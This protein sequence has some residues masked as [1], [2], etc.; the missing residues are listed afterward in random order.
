[1][2][3]I[4]LLSTPPLFAFTFAHPAMLA[5][6]AAAAAPILIHLWSRRR[7]RETTWAA[8]EYL[9]AALRQKRRKL[10]LEHWLLLAVRTLIVVLV[11]LAVAEPIQDRGGLAAAPGER[12]HR[13][14][15]LDGSFS[16]AYTSGDKSRFE[17][18]K[19]IAARIVRE[20]SQGDGFTL[21]VMSSPPRVVVRKPSLESEDFVRELNLL[22]LTHG[23]ADLAGTLKEV[24]QVL[25]AARREEPRLT[26][27][28]IYF[29][30]DL[31]RVGWGL[32][33]IDAATVADLRARSERL[34]EAASLVVIDVGHPDAE[35]LAVTAIR[36]REPFATLSRNFEI[37]ATVKRF[38]P[39]A[40]ARQ[41]VELWADGRRVTQQV[42][43]IPTTG[44][45]SVKFSYRFES[46]G[47]HMLEVRAPGDLL[48]VDNRRW[49]VVP[50]KAS[51]PVLCVDGRSSAGAPDAATRYLALALS[52]PVGRDSPGLV[53]PEIVAESRLP[54]LTLDRFDCIFLA[55]VAQ[56]TA[57]EARLLES[58]VHSGGNLVFFLGDR[59]QAERYNA[60]LG[61]DRPGRIHLLPARL[62]PII[63]RPE[64]RLN[65]LEY[66]H[67]MIE[68]FRG[69][70][71]SGLLTALVMKHIRLVLPD[72]SFS[73]EPTATGN[74]SKARVVLSLA[75]GDPLIVEEPI[76]RGR[77]VLVATSADTTWTYLPLWPSYVP[78]IQETLDFVI[79]GQ[80]ERR[81]VV[82]GE[83]IGGTLPANAGET[84][85]VVRDPRGRSDSVRSRRESDLNVWSFADTMI[86]G[87]YSVGRIANP[88][89]DGAANAAGRVGDPSYGLS[90]TDLFAVNVD[91]A[92]SD[93]AALTVEQLRNEVWPGI[94]FVHQTSL[95]HFDRPALGR[96]SRFSP[97]AID[98]LSGVL[99]LLLVETFLARRF[100]H[101]D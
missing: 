2:E 37:E 41:P 94:P 35:N 26:R 21:L 53:R 36:A 31:G 92:E 15:V 12:R 74:R 23:T 99:V 34:A 27:E 56:F 63:D 60:E 69:R 22:E 14:L 57:A 67:P 38:P 101:H 17:R 76:G 75:S 13:M 4:D 25:V 62:G 5:W 98:L 20:S 9:A 19:E 32:E 11:V 93:L 70:E 24:E 79:R 7:Y 16:M 90:R 64:T 82:V 97:C 89:Y 10:L 44:E 71:R 39:Q 59:V 78:L 73:P 81:N 30:T 8:M 33:G 65:P 3:S 55:D 47:D 66:R 54:E 1:M 42:I 43:D 77:V 83:R 28:E 96:A 91:P 48:E 50:V 87:V 29:L 88:S 45:A 68:A 86:S 61:S 80:I 46:P 49:I 52:P 95:E 84:S 85:L 40:H 58:Y 18:A 72:R 51:I 6:L 100:G